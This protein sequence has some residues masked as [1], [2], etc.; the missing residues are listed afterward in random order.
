MRLS[1]YTVAFTGC[2]PFSASSMDCSNSSSA[3]GEF[4]LQCADGCLD[5]DIDSSELLIVR[6][7]LL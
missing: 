7:L 2:K 1:L 5:F 4:L 3:H 6:A